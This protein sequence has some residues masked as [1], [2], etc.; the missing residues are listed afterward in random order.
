M[1]V[2]ITQIVFP[3]LS[4]REFAPLAAAAGYEVVELC[5]KRDGELTAQSSDAELCQLADDVR[6]A[7]VEPVSLVHAHCTGNLLDSGKAQR[8]SIEETCRGLQVAAAMG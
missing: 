7:G 5:L 6:R 3:E 4:V 1:Q 2:G 8:T